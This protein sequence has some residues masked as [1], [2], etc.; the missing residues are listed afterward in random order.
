MTANVK[1]EIAKRTNAWKDDLFSLQQNPGVIGHHSVETD[2]FKPFLHGTE[3]PHAVV[4]Y[5]NH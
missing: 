4:D 2:F 5:C 1:I 3:I